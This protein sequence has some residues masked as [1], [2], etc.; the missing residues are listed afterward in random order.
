MAKVCVEM[1]SCDRGYIRDAVLDEDTGKSIPI[2]YLC[3]K[4]DGTQ[5][6]DCAYGDG[7]A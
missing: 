3:R 4:C 5:C 1:C 2:D 6:I 7:C